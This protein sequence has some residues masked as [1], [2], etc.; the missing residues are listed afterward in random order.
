MSDVV[1]SA[2]PVAVPSPSTA[3][4]A[5]T[6]VDTAALDAADAT[7]EA[8][9]NTLAADAA[10]ASG[11]PPT[12]TEVKQ[13]KEV[14]K[15]L[16]KLKLKVDGK[17]FDHEIDLN[18]EEGLVRE[19]QMSRMGQKRSQEKADLEKQI[20][21]F[22]TAFQ[23]D[24]FAAMK[25]LGQDPNK[26]IDQYI[27]QQLENAKKSPEQLAREQLE[28]ELKQIKAEREREKEELNAKE[29][30]RLEQQAFT[31]Y[32]MQMEQA[33]SKTDLPRTP[34]TVKKIA[35]YM[36]VALEAGRDVSPE[37]VIP[38]VREEMNSD[39]KE[40][41]S[42]LP[43]DQIEALLGEQ[44]INKLRKRRVAKSQEAAK[45]IGNNKVNETGKS[46]ESKNKVPGEKKNFKDFF[47][48]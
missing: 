8:T 13:A 41:F 44:V 45:L 11:K 47:G 37:D 29:R 23:Q 1:Q 6:S 17:E 27:N 36:L 24:P 20:T 46:L 39:L 26:V 38:L 5:D 34:Y 12:K 2:A 3:S 10:A 19:L 18:D 42:S 16:K 28:K 31:Q 35:D 21:A 48:I 43:E 14:E 33:L 30:T 40:M 15:R 25:D 7:E 32:D 9:E 4:P 22:F